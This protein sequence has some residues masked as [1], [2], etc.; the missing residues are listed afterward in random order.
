MK[1]HVKVICKKASQILCTIARLADVISDHKKPQVFNL[2]TVRCSGRTLNRHIN[3]LHE[4]ALRIAY[5]D[6]ESSF[7][8]LLIK[9]D[10]VTIHQRNLRVLAVE[11]YKISHKLSPEFIRDLVEEINTKQVNQWTPLLPLQRFVTV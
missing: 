11:M 6:Y 7:E 10:S 8:E 4:R 5:E 3:R 9:D 2:A 1:G